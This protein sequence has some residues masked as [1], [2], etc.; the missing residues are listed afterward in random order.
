MFNGFLATVSSGGEQPSIVTPIFRLGWAIGTLLA[1]STST[2]RSL[3]M[4]CSGL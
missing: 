3:E 4:I 1:N 2:S